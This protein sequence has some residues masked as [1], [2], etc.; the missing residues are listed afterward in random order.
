MEPEILKK[1]LSEHKE[2]INL[3]GKKGIK[4]DLQNAD[5]KGADLYCKRC[6]LKLCEFK[7][8]KIDQCK[9]KQFGLER[10]VIIK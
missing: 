9:F 3:A 8:C 6:K 4:A 7:R 10:C 2:F 1:I 5:L